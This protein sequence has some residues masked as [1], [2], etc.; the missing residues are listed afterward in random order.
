METPEPPR[1][2]RRLNPLPNI[3][4][5]DIDITQ[6]NPETNVAAALKEIKEM[7]KRIITKQKEMDGTLKTLKKELLNKNIDLGKSSHSVL[8]ILLI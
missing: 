3:F 2:R 8:N 5:D 1:R 6:E 7:L 4:A